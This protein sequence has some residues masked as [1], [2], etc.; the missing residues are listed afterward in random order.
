MFLVSM[1][2]Q[3]EVRREVDQLDPLICR[4]LS[5]ALILVI[6]F[7]LRLESEPKSWSDPVTRLLTELQ[8]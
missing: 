4:A 1:K 3:P 7:Q 5:S 8:L 6:T 2:F